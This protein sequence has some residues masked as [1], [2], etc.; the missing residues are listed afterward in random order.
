MSSG[1]QSALNTD[2]Q[3]RALAVRDGDS[4]LQVPEPSAALLAGTAPLLA[5]KARA[6]RQEP[7]R[8]KQLL[9]S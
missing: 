7:A 8:Q 6:R 4:A 9:S 2:L 1:L 3:L 5:L